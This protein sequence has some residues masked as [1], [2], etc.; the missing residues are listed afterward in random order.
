M[1]ITRD[2][3]RNL[4]GAHVRAN[5]QRYGWIE[6]AQISVG[7]HGNAVGIVHDDP[8]RAHGA[9]NVGTLG[10]KNCWMW[11]DAVI[12]VQ[13]LHEGDSE[14]AKTS[15]RQINF[16]DDEGEALVASAEIRKVEVEKPCE[17]AKHY[18]RVTFTPVGG[19]AFVVTGEALRDL[20]K[21]M[22]S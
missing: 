21:L 4:I 16:L 6:N 15:T 17:G 5:I 11:D 2:Q 18:L 14:M 7:S 20:V 10:H 1:G 19:K 12:E 22:D 3:A 9:C 13:L 8:S